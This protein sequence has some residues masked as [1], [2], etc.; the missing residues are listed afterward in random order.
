MS[1]RAKLFFKRSSD[2]EFGELGLGQ[3]RVLPGNG[4]AVKVVMRNDTSLAKVLPSL[5]SPSPSTC[6][7]QVLLNVRVTSSL[8]VSCKKNN[9]LLV[10]APNPPLEKVCVRMEGG[11]AVWVAVC[12]TESS[13]QWGNR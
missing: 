10:C 12:L 13:C 1:V 9:V 5:L 8:P 2:P 6:L 11:V 3:L 7:P 4:E